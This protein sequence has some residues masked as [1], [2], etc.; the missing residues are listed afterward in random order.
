MFLCLY[1]Y[2]SI[3]LQIIL[4]YGN[5]SVAIYVNYYSSRIYSHVITVWTI[6]ILNCCVIF[7]EC[8]VT[9]YLIKLVSRCV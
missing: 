3:V 5:Y 8:T 1:P 6:I 7:F 2:T 4:Y 9:N